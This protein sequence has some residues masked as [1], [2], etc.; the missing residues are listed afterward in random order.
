MLKHLLAIG[1]HQRQQLIQGLR[2]HQ[3]QLHAGR[4]VMLPI[5]GPKRLLKG[6]LLNDQGL[7]IAGIKAAQ[8]MPLGHGL[9][10]GGLDQ[11]LPVAAAG[12]KLGLQHLAFG[13]LSRRVQQ[14]LPE[15]IQQPRQGTFQLL[16]R[17]LTEVVA[18]MGLGAGIEL[19]ATGPHKGHQALL[20]GKG[21]AAQ[22]QQVFEKVRQAGKGHRLVM[23]ARRH[24]HA[25]RRPRQIRA[26]KQGH[27]QA[28]GQAQLQRQRLAG[29]FDRRTRG[30]GQGFA[31]VQGSCEHRPPPGPGQLA[32]GRGYLVQKS[33]GYCAA[34]R[35]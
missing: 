6:G 21:R 4:L 19:P 28:I 5:K 32:F 10:Q 3:G 23:A 17:H 8:R 15:H 12:E 7:P 18:V 29:V 25:E 26:A 31:S 30:H 33:Q 24:P 35:R 1:L 16:R 13:T 2:P 27:G 22:K 9:A 20:A 34:P 11:G 14:R